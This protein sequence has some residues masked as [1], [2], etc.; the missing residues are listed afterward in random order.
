MGGRKTIIKRAGMPD[1]IFRTAEY[2]P[3]PNPQVVAIDE[4]AE[5]PAPKSVRQEAKACP[6]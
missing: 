4:R 2:P 3:D 6:R 1:L 5:R